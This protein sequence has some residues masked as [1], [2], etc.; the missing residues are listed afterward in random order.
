MMFFDRGLKVG[1]HII[2]YIKDIT[3][4]TNQYISDNNGSIFIIREIYTKSIILDFVNLESDILE[5]ESTIIENYPL[6]G[7]S[8]Y[9]N[10]SIKWQI[11]K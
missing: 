7:V 1:H 8:T 11:K 6:T 3:N 2:L 9:L 10:F 5:T 4:K